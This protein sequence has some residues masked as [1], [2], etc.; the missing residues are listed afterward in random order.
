MS[1]TLLLDRVVSKV[2]AAFTPQEV[3][4]VEVYGGQFNAEEIDFK[5]YTCPAIFVA[6]R[7]MEPKPDGKHLVG[8]HVKAVEM[9]AFVVATAATRAARMQSAMV[10][11][12]RLALA[13]ERWQPD[14][15]AN[16]ACDIAPLEE[17]ATC[18]NLYNRQ[19]DKRGQALWVVHWVQCINPR[20]KGA[21]WDW[22][23]VQA[24]TLARVAEPAEPA[25]STTPVQAY[26]DVAFAPITTPQP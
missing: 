21:L 22:L 7:G 15:D 6:V 1:A 5:S 14:D 3:K 2:R 8:Q 4:M 10:L 12:E 17:D 18:E 11:S 26:G 16:T 25:P 20:S 9:S 23:T 13:L 19:I 24:D